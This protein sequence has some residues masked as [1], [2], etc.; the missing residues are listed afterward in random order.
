MNIPK[1]NAEATP[2]NT[3]VKEPYHSFNID[4]SAGNIYLWRNE[5]GRRLTIVELLPHSRGPW[6]VHGKTGGNCRSHRG[7]HLSKLCLQNVTQN[8][9]GFVLSLEYHQENNSMT[10]SLAV[11]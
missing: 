9:S 11:T 3:Y 8:S 5:A 2:A 6:M 4:I 7:P 1:S 10:S